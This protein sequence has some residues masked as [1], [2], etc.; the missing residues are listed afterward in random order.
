MSRRHCRRCCCTCVYNNGDLIEHFAEKISSRQNR[1]LFALFF[2]P[3]N[4]ILINLLQ[5]SS[6]SHP[7]NV[8]QSQLCSAK[9]C[10]HLIRIVRLLHLFSEV[11]SGVQIT[12]CYQQVEH[13]ILSQIGWIILTNNG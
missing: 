7:I 11:C 2:H 6:R 3:I 4:S 10:W 1:D 8:N 9:Y 13:F 12:T 5:R